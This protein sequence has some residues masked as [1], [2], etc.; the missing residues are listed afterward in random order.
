M[1][2]WLGRDRNERSGRG[3]GYTS[4]SS[5][6]PTESR[7]SEE[8]YLRN[9]LQ[10]AMKVR[11]L[12][13]RTGVT[14]IGISGEEYVGV[15]KLMNSTRFPVGSRWVH[16][17]Q[18]TRDA[19][20]RSEVEPRWQP[21]PWKECIGIDRMRISSLDCVVLWSLQWIASIR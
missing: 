18:F 4:A 12:L 16:R 9:G 6:L 11:P 20:C 14:D 17:D 8:V 13:N 2:L 3:G 7:R 10:G 21:C 19:G 1:G 5:G 15:C